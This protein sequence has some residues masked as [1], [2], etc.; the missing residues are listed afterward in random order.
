MVGIVISPSR[1]K[2]NPQFRHSFFLLF[3]FAC[4]ERNVRDSLPIEHGLLVQI[5]QPCVLA[6]VAN[7]DC[8]LE[9]SAICASPRLHTCLLYTSD[10]ADE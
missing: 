1:G 2:Y 6:K 8:V 9:P 10:A 3:A 4:K 5:Q 7:L